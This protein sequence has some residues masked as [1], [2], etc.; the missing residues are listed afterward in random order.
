[1]F[2]ADFA[3]DVLQHVGDLRDAHEE[4]KQPRM[5]VRHSFY[6]EE[7]QRGRVAHGIDGEHEAPLDFRGALHEVLRVARERAAHGDEEERIHRDEDDEEIVPRGREEPV[8]Q[9]EDDEK[10]PEQRAMIR[11]ARGC[12]C[13]EFAQREK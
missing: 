1:M 12:E 4:E 13:D 11:A 5:A 8:V 10:C 7:E 3:P 9:R 6:L 2:A